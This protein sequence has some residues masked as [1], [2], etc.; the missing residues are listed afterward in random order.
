MLNPFHTTKFLTG[1]SLLI[2][3]V[4]IMASLVQAQ[5]PNLDQKI[6]VR[7]AGVTLDTVL[8]DLT[9]IS[10]VRFSYSGEIIPAKRKITFHADNAPLRQVLEDIFRQ[11]GI[12]FEI[13]SGY[14]VLTPVRQDASSA[15]PVK[16]E[17]FSVTGTI[18][19]SASH[20][21]MIGAAV[22]V[23]ETG[24]GVITNSYGFFSLT[25]PRGSYTLRASFLGYSTAIREL[26][27][28]GNLIRDIQLKPVPFLMKEIVIPS[29]GLE[30]RILTSSAAQIHVDPASVQRQTA[31]LGETDMLKSLENLPGISFQSEGSS[32]F[33]VRGG[34]RDQNLIL[35]DEAPIYNPT[36]LLGLFTPIIPEAIKNT[37]VYRAD[38]PVQYGGR[39]SS[40]IDIRARDGNMRRFSGSVN[41]SPVSARFNVEGPFKKDASSYFISFR[42]STIGLL[43]KAANPDVDKFHF[44]DFTARFNLKLGQRDRLYLT[45]FSGKDAFI[46][47]AGDVRTGLEWGNS[48]ATLRWSHVYGSRLFSSTTLYGSK[49]DYSLYTNYDE[50]L[51]WNSDITSTNLKS[52]F[53]WYVNPRNAFKF[54]VNVGGYFFNPGNYNA[55]SANL[56]TMRVSEINSG[57]LVAYAGNEL[58]PFSRLKIN[59]GLRLSNWCNYGEAFSI[60][61]DEN[62]N[63]VSMMEYAKGIRYY[64][65]TFLEPRI[66]I[67]FKTG[68]HAS[69][70]A[71]YNRTTQHINQIS[72]SISP[73]NSLEVWLPSGPNIKPQLADIADLGYTIFWPGRSVDLTLDVYY[74]RMY[75]QMGYQDHAEMFL[76]PYLEGELRQ[77]DGFA[78]GFEILLRK[79][80]GKLTGQ[81][82]YGFTR[83]MLQIEELNGGKTYPSHQDRPIDISFSIEYQIKS[84]WLLSLNALYSSGMPLSTPTG[85]FYYRGTQVPVYDELNN[86]RLPDYSRIDLGSTWRLNKAEKAFEHYLTLTLY[87]IFSTHNYAFLNFNKIQSGDGKFY[88]PA[89]RLNKQ[90]QIS[91]YRY[92]YSLVPSFNYN[93]RF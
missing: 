51:A 19:D 60:V 29:T 1:R 70:K 76:N 85:F 47:K 40:V 57:E 89:D 49:Y 61:Y 15:K 68:R 92:I 78:R 48:A 32:Y 7:Y 82:G 12:R 55:A 67:S 72:N 23:G 14:L 10:Q 88:V 91:T 80:H 45:L 69:F 4:L 64:S 6:T 21:L 46:N 62:N 44:A 59:Y 83:S 58:K 41:L 93:L 53:T 34:N 87:N 54:G 63:P 75:N 27:L 56:D 24:I 79:T 39:L 90:G 37:E 22:Y 3:L 9:R 43:V 65:R 84:R 13:V 71:C 8:Q 77:G 26:E 33:S 5:E 66:S 18:I 20:E 11:A 81:L 28:S 35:L 86:D 2:T 73:F 30:D 16:S 25:L 50:K 42:I 36:H 74:K 38:F 17:L 52:E 31:A